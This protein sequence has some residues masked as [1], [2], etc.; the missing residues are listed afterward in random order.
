MTNKKACSVIR[1]YVVQESSKGKLNYISFTFLCLS[2]CMFG[3]YY[4]FL[5]NSL[6][7][8][9]LEIIKNCNIYKRNLGEAEKNNK[10]SKWKKTLNHKKKDV[11]ITKSNENNSKCND[12]NVEEN[13]YNT[14]NDIENTNV[15]NKSNSSTNNINYND[16]SKQLSKTELLEV[17][18]SLKEC[19]SNEDLRNIWTHTIGVAKE[20]FD[21]IQK[22]LKAS[23]QKYLDNDVYI[24][25]NA[26]NRRCLLY[27]LI[28]QEN[29]SRFYKTV[30]FEQ[31][32]Y[33]NDFY[34]LINGEHTLDD[35]LKFIYSFLE[36]FT[37]LINDLHKKHKKDLLQKIT[38]KINKKTLLL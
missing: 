23:I 27:D 29:S 25:Y 7:N 3:F 1:L 36:H 22:D 32:E 11:N 34:R 12:H 14:N 35:I 2:I 18:N 21:D 17:L 13:K 28:W 5:N 20:S 16:T 8:G 6:E 15:E 30:A 24:R 10:G 38:Q 33:T 26:S 19:P 31:L 37:S 4:V 9:S